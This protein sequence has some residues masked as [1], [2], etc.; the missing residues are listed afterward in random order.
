MDNSNLY[1][2]AGQYFTPTIPKTQ[3]DNK[4]KELQE[5]LDQL[6]LLKKRIKYL[7]KKIAF[8]GDVDSVP[9]DLDKDPSGHRNILA[10]HKLMKAELQVEKGWL[11]T[12]VEKTLKR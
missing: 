12:H 7:D 9:I 1:P 3:T 11:L 6:P 5:T 10:V 8:Y 4:K 2:N